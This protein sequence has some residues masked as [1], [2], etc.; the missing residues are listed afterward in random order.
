STRSTDT[1]VLLQVEIIRLDHDYDGQSHAGLCKETGDM[2]ENVDT[3][4]GV[5]AASVLN[6]INN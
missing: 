1:D 2:S 5:S 4:V 6:N 3:F